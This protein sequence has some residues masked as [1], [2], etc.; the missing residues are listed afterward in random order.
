MN[1]LFHTFIY[2]AIIAASVAGLSWTILNIPV[3]MDVAKFVA[4]NAAQAIALMAF[5]A[6][7]LMLARWNN[8][9]RKDYAVA[10]FLSLYSMIVMQ[11]P[12]HVGGM[13]GWDANLVLL[14]G[15]GRWMFYLSAALFAHA[16]LKAECKPWEWGV[17]VV[18]TL[19]IAAFI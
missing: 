13:T 7:A 19:V 17:V 5:P 14:S 3:D 1:L 9:V 10:F 8:F 2:G 15:I 6:A 11:V 16:M 12:V 4:N 18:V